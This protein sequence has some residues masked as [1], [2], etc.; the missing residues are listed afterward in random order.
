VLATPEV[1]QQLETKAVG[2]M[3]AAVRMKARASVAKAISL[4]V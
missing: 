3:G 1:V 2:T 4:E